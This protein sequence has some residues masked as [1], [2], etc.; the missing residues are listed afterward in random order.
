MRPPAW[1]SRF[2]YTHGTS[3]FGLSMAFISWVCKE[4]AWSPLGHSR[5]KHILRA[6]QGP[7][8]TAP[9]GSSVCLA[10]PCLRHVQTL[11]G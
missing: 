4:E 7:G 10:H 9:G 1:L 11:I 6:A 5:R 3:V 2:L 8:D